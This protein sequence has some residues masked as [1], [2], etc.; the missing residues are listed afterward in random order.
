[1]GLTEVDL[2]IQQPIAGVP[3]LKITCGKYFTY[4]PFAFP[5]RMKKVSNN[6]SYAIFK[7]TKTAKLT[8]KTEGSGDTRYNPVVTFEEVEGNVSEQ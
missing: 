5:T 3:V 8:V 2:E 6:E 1:M 7:A 4:L